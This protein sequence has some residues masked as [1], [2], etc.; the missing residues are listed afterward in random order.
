MPWMRQPT[1]SRTTGILLAVGIGVVAGCDTGI[2]D[3]DIDNIT[4][5]ELRLLWLEQQEKTNEPLVLLID[6]RRRGAFEGSRLPGAVHVTL[7]DLALESE[8]DPSVNAYDRIVVYAE[9][10]GALS[11][12]AMTKR[13][14]VL[15]Y[16]QTRLFGGGV[17]E[18]ADA[19]FPIESGE[20][21]N[22]P[23]RDAPRDVRRPVP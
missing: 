20:P 10:P 5:T 9:G 15:G 21:Q 17:V 16:D 8:I 23:Q 14:L 13:L 1:P 2:T 11:G 6:P 22:E 12:R 3:A 19:G 4:L 18:W 7:P